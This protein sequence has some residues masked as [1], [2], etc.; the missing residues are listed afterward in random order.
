[1][2]QI[3]GRLPYCPCFCIIW[4]VPRTVLGCTLLRNVIRHL[5]RDWLSANI[6]CHLLILH[7]GEHIDSKI[8]ECCGRTALHASLSIISDG[9][10]SYL[11]RSVG[12]RSGSQKF[13]IF[14]WVHAY[15][16]PP[17]RPRREITLTSQHGVIVSESCR[18]YS[19]SGS[20]SSPF[21]GLEN[22]DA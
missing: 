1:M 15:F 17:F 11:G 3:F 9:H 10:H 21:P 19:A 14:S 6:F 7:L 22:T 4:P 16:Q 20:I 2:G 12:K 8:P 13:P 18:L 5:V